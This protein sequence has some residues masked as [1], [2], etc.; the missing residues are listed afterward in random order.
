MMV[1]IGRKERKKERKSARG[2]G[3]EEE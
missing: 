3:K 2:R 1:C